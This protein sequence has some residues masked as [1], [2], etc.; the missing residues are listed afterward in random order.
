MALIV[1]DDQGFVA[2]ANAYCDEVFF[3]SYFSDIGIDVS[4]YTLAQQQAAIIQATRYIDMRFRWAGERANRGQTTKWPRWRAFDEDGYYVTGVPIPVK[5]AVC[6]AA[7]RSLQGVSLLPDPTH[8][9][10]GLMVSNKLVKVGPI[11]ESYTYTR[12][13]GAAGAALPAFPAIEMM[14]AHSG[15]TISSLQ[16]SISRG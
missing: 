9:Q 11:E 12:A 6:E 13:P 10:T 14:L 1:Q 7:Y 16:V 2:G 8:D 15:L 3:A 5:N 4:A